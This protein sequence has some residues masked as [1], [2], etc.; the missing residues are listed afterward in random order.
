MLDNGSAAL[1]ITGNGKYTI[2]NALVKSQKVTEPYVAYSLLGNVVNAKDIVVDGVTIDVDNVDGSTAQLYVGGIGYQG[3]AN[4][5]KVSNLTIDI[6]EDVKVSMYNV[7]GGLISAPS[8]ASEGNTVSDISINING[9][10]T[11]GPV[12]GMFGVMGKA[13][14]DGNSVR[15]KETAAVKYPL[16]GAWTVYASTD[17]AAC[18]VVGSTEE[19]PIAP[20]VGVI[21]FNPTNVSPGTQ[22]WLN[23]DDECSAPYY[24]EIK[25]GVDYAYNVKINGKEV[26]VYKPE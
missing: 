26:P 13:T 6:A 4:G 17:V 23:F 12:G 24:S 18:S 3:S 8:A 15:Y 20:V 10:E 2:S 9:N 16:L 25:N 5:V 11:V 22:I 21:T 7:V 19:N 14:F 1:N